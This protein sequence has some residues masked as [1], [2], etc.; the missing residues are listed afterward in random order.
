M[1]RRGALAAAG[2][3]LAA[4]LVVGGF[5]AAPWVRVYTGAAPPQQYDR[6]L[7][8]PVAAPT[9]DVLV[10]AHNAGNNATTTGGRWSMARTSSRSM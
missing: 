1:G 7:S 6:P 2:A 5:L 9:R 10:A 8:P 3:A 4:A